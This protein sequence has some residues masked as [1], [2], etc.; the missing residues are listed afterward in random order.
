MNVFTDKLDNGLDKDKKNFVREDG[1]KVNDLFWCC[2]NQGLNFFY[3][4]IQPNSARDF[5]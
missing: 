5:L 4:Q 2:L 3:L 1:V